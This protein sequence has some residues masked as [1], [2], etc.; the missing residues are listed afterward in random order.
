[1]AMLIIVSTHSVAMAG[2][3]QGMD[4]SPVYNDQSQAMDLKGTALKRA[5]FIKAFVAGCYLGRGISPQE[6]LSDVPKRIEVSYFVHIPGIKLTRYTK[7]LMQKNIS[8]S[9]Y[10]GLSDELKL[11]QEY[12]VDLNPGDRYALTYIPDVGTRFEHN[13]RLVGIIKGELFAK[14]VFSVWLG[15]RPMDLSVKNKILGLS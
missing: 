12:F 7:D 1:M 3:G 14:A 15:E 5:F 6:V 13:G 8:A 9:E 10:R 4:F 2:D 11:M